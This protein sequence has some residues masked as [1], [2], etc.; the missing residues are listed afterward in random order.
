MDWRENASSLSEMVE[1]LYSLPGKMMF[2]DITFVLSDGSEVEAHKLILA[3]A[4]PVFQTEF[5]GGG[6]WVENSSARVPIQDDMGVFRELLGF[7]YKQKKDLGPLDAFQ[8]W[9]LLYLCDK[10]L[11]TR[12]SGPYGPLKILAPAES[13]LALLTKIVRFAHI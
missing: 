11:I 12:I 3:I 9:G 8:L 2:A 13:L 10:Y 4:S 1:N 5:Y 7:I 6:Q